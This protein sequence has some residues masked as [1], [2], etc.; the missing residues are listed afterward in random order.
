MPKIMLLSINWALNEV[1]TEFFT[2]P[3]AFKQAVVLLDT[4]ED[5][6]SYK[7]WRHSIYFG[8][9]AETTSTPT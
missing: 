1:R 9:N 2:G 8:T 3:D 5:T 4:L 7:G 6:P